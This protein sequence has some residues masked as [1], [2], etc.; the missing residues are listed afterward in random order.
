MSEP[1]TATA[2]IV[3]TYTVAGLIH[4]LRH[5]CAYNV[6]LGTNQLVDRDGITTILWTL[7]AQY[8]WDKARA[9]FTAATVPVPPIA[10][11]QARSG[12]F[13]NPV[14]IANLTGV[15]SHAGTYSQASQATFV[16]R[17]TLFKKLRVIYL[18]PALG[19]VFH[20]V[21]GGGLDTAL[22]ALADS[23]GGFDASANAPYRWVK[24][25]GDRFLAATGV[26]AGFTLDLNDK[27][28]RARN[29]E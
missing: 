28:K 24:S 3:F 21:N 10:E 12:L 4:R 2:R 17:D 18:E 15:G 1:L 22:S 29:L 26:S 23:Y 11:L 25:R 16:L 14:E 13:W 20:S 6:V 27:L 9:I 19:Y 8:L 5:Y 7:A